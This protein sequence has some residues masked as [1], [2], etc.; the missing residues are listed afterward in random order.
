MRK[1]AAALALALALVAIACSGD[2]S[3]VD[4]PTPTATLASS[5]IPTVAPTPTAA[6]EDPASAVDFDVEAAMEH[7]RVLAVEI[8]L[9]N[10]GSE[11]DERAA[12]YIAGRL[13]AF[14]YEATQQN[15]PLPQGG[16]STNV[17]G[18]PPGFQPDRPYHIVGG[19]RDSLNG[20]GGNDNATGIAAAL[21]IV[22][23][24]VDSPAALPVVFVAFG[25]EE[26]QP[27]PERE[28]HVGSLHFVRQMTQDQRSN[29]VAY[30]NLDMIGRGDPIY[31]G[32]LDVGPREAT[33]RLLATGGA[34]GI[35]VRERV[36]PDWSDNGSFLTEGMNAGWLWTGDDPCCIH[37][38]K[39]TIDRVRSADLERAGRVAL[40]TLRS[41]T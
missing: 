11:G 26:V 13:E 31:A 21:E 14:S 12:S 39:D 19:H 10:A 24:V 29:L 32:R 8:G 16:E 18:I 33:D 3:V 37:T 40:A 1:L 41:Y 27:V 7:V 2:P 34:L 35:D 17:I 9:R 20:P 36:T 6:P 15:F 4:A 23:S 30:I 38:P 28:H 22:R 25:A 5:P